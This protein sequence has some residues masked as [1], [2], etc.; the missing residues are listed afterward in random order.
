M[1]SSNGLIMEETF[2]QCT[3]EK[4]LLNFVNSNQISTVITLFRL[5]WHQ[6][7]F[8]L[9]TNQSE[10]CNYNPIWYGLTRFSIEF[11]V[12]RR[13]IYTVIMKQIV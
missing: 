1:L 9:A 5:I 4:Y 11:S 13:M 12:Y 7:E 6:M 2:H 3:A 8:R 10:K